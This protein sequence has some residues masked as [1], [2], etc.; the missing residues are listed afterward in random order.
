MAKGY[1]PV[2]RD[3]GFL[4]PPDMREWL[5]ADHPVWLLITVVADHLDT[6]AVHRHRKLGG[7]GRAG[8]HPDM[9]L[10]LLVWGWARGVRSSRRIERLC[11]E[12]VSFR[13]ICAGD[14]P[15]H[16]TLSRFRAE[17]AG[18][19]E[20]LFAE[21]LRLCAR[22]GM[23][24][25]DTI[26]LDGTKIAANAAKSANR[27]ADGLRKLA[28]RIV[29]EHAATDASEDEHF[30][31][32]RRGDEVPE[33]VADPDTGYE[34]IRA[35][36]AELQAEDQAA[37]S[38]E[39]Q[40]Q[41]ELAAD[42]RIDPD[43]EGPTPRGKVPEAIAVQ[44]AEVELRRAIADQQ[45]KID[46]YP[47]RLAE[48]LARG[49]RGLRSPVP[50]EQ[51][52]RVRRARTRLDKARLR[53]QRRAEQQ[54]ERDASARKPVRNLT[55]PDSRLL[56]VRGGGWI[57]G[58]NCQAL[59]SADGLI[60]ATSVNNN[61]ADVITFEPMMRQAEAA[62]ETIT[63]ARDEHASAEGIGLLLADAGYFSEDNLTTKGPDRLIALGKA[64]DTER[65]ARSGPAHGP[66]PA[67][68]TPK[69]AMAHRLRTPEGLAAYR[70][71]SHIAETPFGHAKH[72][73]GF[74]QFSRRGITAVTGEWTFHSLAHNLSKIL[75]TGQTLPTS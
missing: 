59:T 71:R 38:A 46:S 20:E 51:H 44:A 42:R 10:T 24:R 1:R 18:V 13:V 35:A 56:P 48:S 47:V 12:D 37:R 33:D 28:E 23:G 69:E 49:A 7:A 32:H 70:Q 63:H 72:N 4:L 9:L 45:A 27:D 14:G 29:A 34:R 66:P 61:P 25:L 31:A 64:R 30:G 40:R 58:Y 52:H 43:D 41:A 17:L 15:D 74:R 39:A 53:Q 68:A 67:D 75:G 57:Q 8:D 54:A 19:V 5:P 11:Q 22:L 65:A 6:D 3:Q 26:A 21:V 16:V 50:V 62:A 73:W 60:L 36:L 55:D 2:L